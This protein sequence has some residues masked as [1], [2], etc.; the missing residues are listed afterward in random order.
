MIVLNW[1]GDIK[2]K[3]PSQILQIIA[4]I[5]QPEFAKI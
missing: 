4:H 2:E 1:K 5:L 3:L